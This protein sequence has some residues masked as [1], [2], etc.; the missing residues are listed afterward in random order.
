MLGSIALLQL[1]AAAG[2]QATAADPCDVG[3]GKEIVVCG[4]RNSQSRYRLPNLPRKYDRKPLTAETNAIPG[5]HTRAHID[6][7]VRA[8][9]LQDNRV[10]VTF[11]LPF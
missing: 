5:V 7:A 8:D 10:M 11:S 1:A 9:G 3:S 4:S 2:L 6:S